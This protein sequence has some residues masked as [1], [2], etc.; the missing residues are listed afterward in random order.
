M[1]VCMY[2]CMYVTKWADMIDCEWSSSAVPI[3]GEYKYPSLLNRNNS[4]A[5]TA[6]PPITSFHGALELSMGG[7][8]AFTNNPDAKDRN[9]ND[10]SKD[11]I[12]WKRVCGPQLFEAVDVNNWHSSLVSARKSF[13]PTRSKFPLL[14][15]RILN[16]IESLYRRL[17]MAIR[18]SRM[19]ETLTA[20]CFRNKLCSLSDIYG[21]LSITFL[22]ATD[23]LF[24][25]AS[26]NSKSSILNPRPQNSSEYFTALMYY[27]WKMYMLNIYSENHFSFNKPQYE[28]YSPI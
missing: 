21:R 23:L 25:V 16:S 6:A 8:T 19:S 14:S 22:I 12:I 26:F 13:R 5:P 20:F 11:G 7:G 3:K 27:I 15:Q 2:V 28:H 17:C 18:E 24:W 10:P 1:Y 9:A 4:A